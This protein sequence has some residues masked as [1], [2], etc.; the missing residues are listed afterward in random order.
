MK[1]STES[2]IFNLPLKVWYKQLVCVCVLQVDS[3]TIWNEVHS[4]SAARLAV[5]SVV[6]LVFKVASG[7]LKVCS[8]SLC[9]FMYKSKNKPYTNTWKERCTIQL[10]PKNLKKRVRN[11]PLKVSLAP[12]RH[13]SPPCKPS[14]PASLPVS[15]PKA[16]YCLNPAGKPEAQAL[17]TPTVPTKRPSLLVLHHNHLQSSGRVLR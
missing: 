13:T 9:L 10:L 17:Q 12:S 15:V 16:A 3:D 8:Q 7:E 6:E 5:G 4:S 11:I 14:P 2:H 1:N